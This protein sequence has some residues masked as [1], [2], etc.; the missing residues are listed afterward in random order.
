MKSNAEA[1]ARQTL[2]YVI[3][4]AKENRLLHK[5]V[6]LLRAALAQQAAQKP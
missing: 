5:E 1:S 2:G 3:R 4:L 6:K